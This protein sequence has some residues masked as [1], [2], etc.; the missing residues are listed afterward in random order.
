MKKR[1][2]QL[3]ANYRYLTHSSNGQLDVEYLDKDMQLKESRYLIKF[4]NH[5][6]IGNHIDFDINGLS[7]GTYTFVVYFFDASNGIMCGTGGVI[8]RTVDGGAN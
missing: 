5:S 3:N 6:D 2:D 4:N 7:K 1:G 8:Y